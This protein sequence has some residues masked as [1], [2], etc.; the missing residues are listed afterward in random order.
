MS[1]FEFRF[2]CADAKESC[3]HVKSLMGEFTDIADIENKPYRHT[4]RIFLPSIDDAFA[5]KKRIE[6]EAG[7]ALSSIIIIAAR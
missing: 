2:L 3:T 5:V 6:D 4:G 1:E 7:E